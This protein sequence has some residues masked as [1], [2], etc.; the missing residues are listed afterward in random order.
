MK[1]RQKHA[2][3]KVDTFYNTFLGSTAVFPE[4]GF[5]S[6]CI[7]HTHR[8][9]F[10]SPVDSGYAVFARSSRDRTNRSTDTSI[11]CCYNGTIKEKNWILK[12]FFFCALCS[13][14]GVVVDVV[15]VVFSR[16]SGVGFSDDDYAATSDFF[17]VFP[18]PLGKT[19][20]T[21]RRRLFI[22]H[23]KWLCLP[24][25]VSRQ[26]EMPNSRL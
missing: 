22:S 8:D 6:L 25:T 20:Q 5:V 7:L 15:V 21:N 19:K 11:L 24:C 3:F 10:F 17:F 23:H 9:L 26:L 16:H 14:V 18:H 12:T 13:C 1:E 4:R 2:F